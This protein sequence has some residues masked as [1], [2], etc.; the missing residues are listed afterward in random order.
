MRQILQPEIKINY[1]PDKNR[2][3]EHNYQLSKLYQ[4]TKKSTGDIIKKYEEISYNS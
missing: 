3:D 1:L 4:T 2:N